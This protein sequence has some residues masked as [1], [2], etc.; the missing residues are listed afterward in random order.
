MKIL[1]VFF[2]FLTFY[3]CFL[4][5]QIRYNVDDIPTHLKKNAQSVIREDLRQLTIV[6]EKKAKLDVS[7]AITVLNEN[8]IE[9]AFFTY[10][11]SS[12]QK[13]KNVKATVY[14]RTGSKLKK[15]PRSD[16]IDHSAISGFSLF[17]DNRIL[18]ID[19]EKRDYPY[20]VKYEFSLIFNGTLNLPHWFPVQGFGKALEHAHL[21]VI[22]PTKLG[23][24]YHEINLDDTVK[25]SNTK[26]YIQYNWKLRDIQAIK[27]EPFSKPMIENIPGVLLG[28][29][30]FSIMNSSGHIGTWESFGKWYYELNDNRQSLPIE[31]VT[32]VK[33]LVK[34]LDNNL[35][36]VKKLY[37]YLQDNTRY[38][39]IQIG[40]GGWQAL[41]AETVDRLKYGD[42]K[43]LTNYMHALL[44]VINIDSYPTLVKAGRNKVGIV[45]DFP[46][47]QFNHAILCVPIENDTIWLE[48]TSQTNP[49]GYLGTFTDDRKVL[50]VSKNGGRI[51]RTPCYGMKENVKNTNAI[52]KLMENGKGNVKFSRTFKGIFYENAD[53][54]MRTDMDNKEKLIY[55]SINIPHFTLK[56]FTHEAFK[57]NIPYIVENVELEL[58][59][60]ATK[61]GD[62]IFFSPN[63]LS[64]FNYIPKPSSARASDI[65]IY[66]SYMKSDTI[67]FEIPQDYEVSGVPESVNISSKFGHYWSKV[68]INNKQIIYVRNLKINKGEYLKESYPELFEFIEK[69]T[70]A[71]RKKISLQKQ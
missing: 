51:D 19:P 41:D 66:R 33:N 25:I 40:I 56:N 60:Y 67:I 1:F 31:S 13:I 11:Y 5:S 9:D 28:M 7:Y 23:I 37:N 20:T 62:N 47:N 22:T 24:R 14:D 46:S 71:D 32:A 26:K 69:I 53:I 12:F 35:E 68:N 58:G 38:V 3:P 57:E 27:Q 16:F 43:A 61:M 15:I 48:C 34:D 29:Y 54:V 4:I 52:V 55:E 44:K 30:N 8:G 6:S 18:F 17:E 59:N 70:I 42:C 39:S 49:F 63:L 36:K 10:P 64:T 65:M 2:F 50:V 45:V 21:R